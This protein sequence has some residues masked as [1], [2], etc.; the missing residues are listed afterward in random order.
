MNVKSNFSLMAYNIYTL[1]GYG[2]TSRGLG[3]EMK[4]SFYKSE[5]K[6]QCFSEKKKLKYDFTARDVQ[7]T[8]I[9]CTSELLYNLLSK[10]T[11]F[12]VCLNI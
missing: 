5:I 7:E 10:I 2:W 6:W 1:V 8:D 3:M 9:P 4:S 11:V 12:V